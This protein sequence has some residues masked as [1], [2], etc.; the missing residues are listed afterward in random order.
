LEH[1]RQ[2]RIV[3]ACL[4]I[5]GIFL[6]ILFKLGN[7]Q[8]V[9]GA[10]LARKALYQRSQEV[11]LEL[12]ERGNIYDRKLRSLSDSGFAERLVVFPALVGDKHLVARNLASLLGVTESEVLTRLAGRYGAWPYPLTPEQAK[13]IKAA[14]LPGVLVMPVRF[15]YGPQAL[16]ANLIGYLGKI[17]S[18]SELKRLTGTGK[19]YRLSDYVGKM[20]LERY[21]E[22]ELK[23]KRP[24]RAV[25][26]LVDARDK[27]I[28]GLG[29]QEVKHREDSTRR[30]LVLTLDR[31]I[32]QIVEEVL[33][34]RVKK[35]AVVV[36]DAKTGDLLALASRPSYNQNSVAKAIYGQE[37]S[38]FDRTVDRTVLLAQPGSVFKVVVGA[39][40][41]DTGLVNSQDIFE[42]RGDAE[43][44]KCQVSTEHRY[45]SFATAMALSCNPTFVKVGLQLGSDT[46]IEYAKKFGLDTQKVIGYPFRP[47]RHQDWYKVGEENQLVN[48]SIGQGPVLASPVQITAMMNTIANGGMYIEPRLVK[49]IRGSDGRLLKIFPLGKSHRAVSPETAH[50]IQGMLERVIQEGTGREAGITGYQVAGKTGSA[51]VNKKAGTINAWFSGYAPVPEPRY[52]ITVLVEEGESG[53]KTAAPV[54]REI[55]QRLKELPIS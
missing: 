18:S 19:L 45:H 12:V 33:N 31:D 7:I 23:G 30:H 3:Q 42:C 49:E 22:T 48:S 43:P 37:G 50:A 53:G 32:Q 21:Y 4:L 39:A 41:L 9:N 52:V 36:M 10:E 38:Y 29:I 51:E 47:D 25:R 20:G 15:R 34:T 8:L 26:A 54:F 46:L 44:V 24:E 35:G 14:K 1:L 55:L 13:A 16:A 5:F 27:L 40:A 6:P 2:R 28:P 17:E 11:S